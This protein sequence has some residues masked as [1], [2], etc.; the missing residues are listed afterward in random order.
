MYTKGLGLRAGGQQQESHAAFLE[1][2]LRD[3]ARA[4]PT[5]CS[6]HPT[7]QT[8]HPTLYTLQPT[9]YHNLHPTP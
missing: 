8:L 2:A 6:P 4:H 5:P 7:P 3:Q 9:P 1:H